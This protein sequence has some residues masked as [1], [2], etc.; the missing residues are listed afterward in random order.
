MT[1]LINSVILVALLTPYPN[2]S[3][4]FLSYQCSTLGREGGFIQLYGLTPAHHGQEYRQSSA[5][6]YC[7][8]HHLSTNLVNLRMLDARLTARLAKVLDCVGR[9]EVIYCFDS[10]RSRLEKIMKKGEVLSS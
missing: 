10:Y 1:F 5:L 4:T 2:S 9:R 8:T 6:L 7:V 3:L